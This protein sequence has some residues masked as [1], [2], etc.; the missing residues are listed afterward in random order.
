MHEYKH[1]LAVRVKRFI[2]LL[3]LRQF[4][5]FP[6]D[7][8]V[9]IVEKEHRQGVVSNAWGSLD[10]LEILEKLPL[11][12]NDAKLEIFGGRKANRNAGRKVAWV[13]VYRLKSRAAPLTWLARNGGV[14]SEIK[15]PEPEK[16][17]Q[18]ELLAA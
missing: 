14:P 10:A 15:P 11:N 7:V 9:D 3:A 18:Q 17:V 5:V 13:G 2:V 12:F 8:P 16:V 4:Y 6:G 1:E